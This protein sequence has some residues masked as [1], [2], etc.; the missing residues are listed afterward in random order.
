M[1]V[2]SSNSSVLFL[3]S[4]CP[5]LSPVSSE[6]FFCLLLYIFTRNSFVAFLSACDVALCCF[7][8]LFDFFFCSAFPFLPQ[9]FLL[10][11]LYSLCVIPP[12]PLASRMCWLIGSFKEKMERWAFAVGWLSI[13]EGLLGVLAYGERM[14]G[15]GL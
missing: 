7:Y 12:P 5:Q 4:M 6:V 2:S 3:F 1:F 8:F 10:N 14:L 11:C 15:D 13:V 9:L